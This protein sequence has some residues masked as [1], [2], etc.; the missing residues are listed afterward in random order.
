MRLRTVRILA[1][2]VAVG[3]VVLVLAIVTSL[4]APRVWPRWFVRSGVQI[5]M[6]KGRLSIAHLRWASRSTG[7][8][9]GLRVRGEGGG[10]WLTLQ[11]YDR[12]GA[13]LVATPTLYAMQGRG[14]PFSM[15]MP[16]PAATA[17]PQLSVSLSAWVIA[18]PW[19]LAPLTLAAAA[20]LYFARSYH[21]RAGLCNRCGYD[22]RATPDRCPEC[23]TAARN[24][25]TAAA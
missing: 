16:G 22:L 15:P 13:R 3:W 25:A 9:I 24:G 14:V 18:W 11:V 4:D 20:M 5:G 10:I 12:G 19:L 21:R 1:A 7:T 23:G 6:Y 17:P 2:I 8:T